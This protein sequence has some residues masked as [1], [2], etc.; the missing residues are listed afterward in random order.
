MRKRLKTG[1]M[2]VAA[3]SLL[4]LGACK[5]GQPKGVIKP[6]EMENVLYDYYLAEAMADNLPYEE[7]YKKSLYTQHVFDK[8]RIT[9][10]QFDSSMVWY[11]RRAAELTKIYEQVNRRLKDR[12]N[13]LNHQIAQRDKKPGATQKGD[14][15]DIWYQDRLL[16][17]TGSPASN[18]LLFRIPSDDNFK[19]GDEFCLTV[20]FVF[21]GDLPKENRAVMALTIRLEN[22]SVV[23]RIFP[24]SRSGMSDIRL[25]SDTLSAVREVSGFVYYAGGEGERNSLLLDRIALIRYHRIYK[26][27]DETPGE[28][29]VTNMPQP[30]IGTQQNTG[31]RT[32]QKSDLPDMMLQNEETDGVKPERR[33]P[34]NLDR[35]K[36]KKP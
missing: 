34:H 16:C 3:A 18:K 1:W 25:K 36:V 6:A 35:P 4:V 7:S 8:Y 22:D 17:L 20:R 23:N 10:A 28:I 14:S 29:P 9:Q 32:M 5:E 15:V 24:V 30:K 21:F 33:N 12:Q 19:I 2:V 26:K 27:K 11:T 31:V 13:A